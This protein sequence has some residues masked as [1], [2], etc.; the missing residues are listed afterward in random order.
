MAQRA[1]T[2]SRTVGGHADGRHHLVGKGSREGGLPA[3][4]AKRNRSRTAAGPL[5][6]L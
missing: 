4:F 1:M 5:V 3:P 2:T 6:T